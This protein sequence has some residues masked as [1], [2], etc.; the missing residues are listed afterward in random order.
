MLETNVT[1]VPAVDPEDLARAQVYRLLSAF[2]SAAPDKEKLEIAAALEGDETPMGKAV[3]RFATIAAKTDRATVSQEYND[4]F[5]GLGRGELLP[6]G[7]YYLTGFLHEKPLARLRNA[8]SR[9]GIERDPAI[10][11]PED[12]IA[13]VTEVMAGL[14]MG[15]FGEP[16]DLDIQHTFFEDHVGSWA[17]HFFADLEKA[18][19]SVL[20]AALGLVGKEFMEIEREAFALD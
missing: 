3:G 9:L 6:Y 10:K 2:L 5:I 19:S 7:S 18:K 4:L 12:H 11:E 17:P 13:F 14:I 15:D 16:Q 8:L 20:Y 1:S